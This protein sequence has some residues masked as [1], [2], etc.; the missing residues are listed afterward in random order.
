V[1][2]RLGV[3]GAGVI[4]QDLVSVWARLGAQVTVLEAQDRFIPAA[5]EAVSKEALKTFTK[6]HLD[7][8]LG[9]R[10]TG[11]NDEGEEVLVS[12]TDPAGEQSI[13]YERLILTLKPPPQ[14]TD[15]L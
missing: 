9:P 3:I 11:S 10:E 14:T 6:Q 13:T 8:T 4:V 12:Y 5:D 15:H 7:I 2:Q 1:Q